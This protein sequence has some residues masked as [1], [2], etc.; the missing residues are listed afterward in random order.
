M[1]VT[2][3]TFRDAVGNALTI[4]KTTGTSTQTGTLSGNT[5]GVSGTPN[6][7]SAEGD[8]VK[9]QTAGQGTLTWTVNN[10]QIHGYNNFGVEVLAGGGATAQ[11]GVVNA[12]ITNNTIDQPGNTVG[13]LGIA[14][15]GVHLNIG[16]VVGDTY[17]ACA[18]ITGNSLAS[19]G[20]DAVPA[21]GGGQDIRLRQR[22][23]TTIRLPG[24][25]GGATDTTAVQNFV[26]GNNSSGGPSV[27]A[28]TNSP[29]GGGFTGTGASCP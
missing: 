6:S 22:Q 2:G 7:G 29:P 4:V 25:A 26:A 24:Y 13:T 20:A 3:N 5:I 18:V 10:N 9:L 23:S 21:V 14:K 17:A 11:S 19:A 16:T 8:G 15:N 12:T 28:S 1:S 27:I